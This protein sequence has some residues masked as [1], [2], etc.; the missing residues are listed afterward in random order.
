M[1]RININI[2]EK[3]I[4]N[5][6]EGTIGGRSSEIDS[7]SSKYMVFIIINSLTNLSFTGPGTVTYLDGTPFTAGEID[8]ST[9]ATFFVEIEG[10][11]APN[12]QLNTVTRTVTCELRNVF[13]GQL[14][15]SQEFHRN[16]NG[17]FC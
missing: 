17:N 7:C 12:S 1:G 8:I 9:N 3:L 11:Q 13:T 14:I 5:Q 16:F 6:L 2:D 10:Y 15:D 4:V